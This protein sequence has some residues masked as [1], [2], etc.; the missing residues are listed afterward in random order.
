ML[1]TVPAALR[2][3]GAG[4]TILATAKHPHQHA[5]ARG[6]GADRVVSPRTLG[7]V[8]RSLTG[9]FVLDGGQLT[10]AIDGDVEVKLNA[11][12]KG[13]L[14]VVAAV[15]DQRYA[16]AAAI[17]AAGVVATPANSSFNEAVVEAGRLSILNGGRTVEITAQGVRFRE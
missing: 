9:A 10:S 1:L 2:S 8:V 15:E 16:G 11:A 3:E 6:L 4:G 12:P 13:P 14:L 17:D 7:R 5:L